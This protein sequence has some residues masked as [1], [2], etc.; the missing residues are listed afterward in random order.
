MGLS[1]FEVAVKKVP[2]VIQCVAKHLFDCEI[3]SKDLLNPSTV[4]TI[5]DEGQY[6]A[7]QFIASKMQELDN[8]GLNHDGTSRR[9]QKLMDTMVT[10]ST[11]M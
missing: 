3:S 5:V 10:L 6:A 1:G 2:T 11:G 9:K 4:Q 8:W 7:K